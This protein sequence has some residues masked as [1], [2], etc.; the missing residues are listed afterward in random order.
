[1]LLDLDLHAAIRA[2]DAAAEGGTGLVTADGRVLAV[3]VMRDALQQ[4]LAASDNARCFHTP[5]QWVR[6]EVGPIS[7]CR[8]DQ[9]MS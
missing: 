3:T 2:R 4:M 7:A 5:G 6:G 9:R 1:M 8:G